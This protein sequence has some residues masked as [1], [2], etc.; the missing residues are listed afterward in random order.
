MDTSAPRAVFA[1]HDGSVEAA[2]FLPGSRLAT[3]GEDGKVRTWVTQL[4]PSLRPA[5]GTTPPE[6]TQDPRATIDGKVV[7]LDNGVTLRGHRDDVLSVEFSP[8]GRRVVTASKDGDA[9]IWNARTGRSKVL[10]GHGGTVFDASFSPD[11]TWVV[12][13]GPS[14][15]GLWLAATAECWYFLRGDGTPVRA[16]AFVS[17]RRIV[18]LGGDGVRS[19]FCNVC[20][21]LTS[22]V[23]LAEK[24][25][26][27]TGRELTQGERLTYL[28]ER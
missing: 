1:G 16:A 25:L 24:R 10:S 5:P 9:R 13:G 4:Q 7:R 26:A 22:L 8:D 20:G 27:G 12:T 19:Y 14:T 2:I 15:A 21:G 6:P 23:A 18:T 11:G 28:G 17:P 3:G